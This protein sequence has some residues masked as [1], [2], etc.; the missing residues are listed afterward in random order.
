MNSRERVVRAIEFGTPDRIPVM[1]WTLPGAYRVY[2]ARLEAL[3]KQYPSD[4]LLSPIYH[5][6]FGLTGIAD[7]STPDPG[8]ITRDHWDVLWKHLSSDYEGLPIEYPLADYA[9]LD[10]YSFPDPLL[11]RE[12]ADYM[13]ELV[14]QD[15][16]RHYVI[17]Y[18]GN[19]WQ[20]LHK[21]RGF[22]NCLLDLMDGREEFLYLIDRMT[23]Y[24]LTRIAFWSEFDEVDGLHIGDDWGTQTQLMIRP[25]LW[26]KIFKPVYRKLVE[27]VHAGGKHA[28]LHS[29]GNVQDIVPDLVEIG[30]DT[31]NLQVWCMNAEKL[32]HDFAG[33]ICFRG[34]LDRQYVLPKG[35]PE[36]VRD[37]VRH[38]REIFATP[39]GGYIYYGQVGPDVPLA[40]IEAMLKTFYE[41]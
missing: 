34:E 28:H 36:D 16:H 35:T 26:R 10:D 30:F 41:D 17:S 12:G 9:A 32:G 4:V 38:A 37:H 14:R 3:Y 7:R 25:E 5:K 15:H 40:N 23:D 20:Q 1:H 27:A 21:L 18:V 22:E 24:L 8:T 33:K 29:D 19:L 2:G 6:P 39:Q 13:V 31:L 11:G